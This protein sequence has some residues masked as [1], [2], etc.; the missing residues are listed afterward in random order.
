MSIAQSIAPRGLA[1]ALMLALST[2]ALGQAM[3]PRD[4]QDTIPETEEQAVE[5]VLQPFS[6]PVEEEE[7]AEELE[8][9][10]VNSTRMMV[11]RALEKLAEAMPG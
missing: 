6:D 4:T 3:G 5:E 2:A 10:S 9:P 1:L 8:R 7:I 11:V